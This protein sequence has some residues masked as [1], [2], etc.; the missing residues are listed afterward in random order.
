MVAGRW[1]EKGCKSSLRV[2]AF[3]GA[4]KLFFTVVESGTQEFRNCIPSAF[5]ELLIS[6]L[7]M[8]A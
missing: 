5:P 4:K 3:I 6:S 7:R 2:F 8:N 1:P